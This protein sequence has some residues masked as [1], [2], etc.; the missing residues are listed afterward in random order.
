MLFFTKFE[1]LF[2]SGLCGLI[3]GSFINVLIYRVPKIIL[4]EYDL[5]SINYFKSHL[6]NKLLR[7]IGPVKVR[8]K[9]RNL[10]VP[11]STSQEYNIF[12]PSSYCPK[13]KTK[14]RFFDNIPIISYLIL[15]GKCRSCFS[16]IGVTYPAVE[17]IST[18]GSVGLAYLIIIEHDF[19]DS[20]MILNLIFF[21]ILFLLSIAMF[22]IDCRFKLLPDALTLPVGFLGIVFCTFKSSHID[23]NDS[24]FGGLVGFF[25]LW[26]LFWLY[27]VFSGKE[28]LGRGDIK[29]TGALGAWVGVSNIMD[30]L[31]IASILGLLVCALMISLKKHS[32]NQTI[33][34]GP[35][36]ILG[37]HFI[38]IKEFLL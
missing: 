19:A 12:F 13:C 14:I 8:K 20:R 10:I 23:I 37:T 28:G 29:L 34:F 16:P 1:F 4:H 15:K 26:I 5:A 25:V 7:R 38:I 32:Y 17:F 30:V 2:F 33:A 36:L 11:A 3:F 31:L 24:I 6:K 18:I 35:F 22:I 21:N 9:I 27:K